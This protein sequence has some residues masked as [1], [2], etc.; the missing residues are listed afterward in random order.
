VV[1]DPLS[2]DKGTAPCAIIAPPAASGQGPKARKELADQTG[3][4][5]WRIP[6][7]K[8]MASG[9]IGG[10]RAEVGNFSTDFA[11]QFHELA[12][13]IYHRPREFREASKR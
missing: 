12:A 9:F 2:D 5:A 3:R 1:D 6:T 10:S 11:G 13:A 7:S 8:K 4:E